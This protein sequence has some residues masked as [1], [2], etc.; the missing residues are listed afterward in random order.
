MLENSENLNN[1]A[2]QLAAKGEYKEAIACFKKAIILESSNYL[3]WYNM[4]IT[5]RDSGDLSAAK[6]CM[7]RAY[8][9]SPDDGD[10]TETLALI[11]HAMG[12]SAEALHY[13]YVGLSRSETN[14]RLWN[15][16]GVVYF[17]K[18]EYSDAAE[19]FEA[20]LTLDPYYYD[21][22]FNLRDTYTELKNFK[23]ANECNRRL[24]ELKH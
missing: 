19:A 21:A 24:K 22:L 8:E 14:S 13:C 1:Q 4:G 16:V 3:L 7:K 5:Y 9:L 11:C 20:A 17:S 12:R 18:T 10:V 23:G 6:D 2:I 15:T